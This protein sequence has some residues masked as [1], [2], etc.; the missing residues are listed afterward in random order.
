M[1]RSEV[2][3]IWCGF[4]AF[5]CFAIAALMVQDEGLFAGIAR[6]QA[7]LVPLAVF[8]AVL[9]SLLVVTIRSLRGQDSPRVRWQSGLFRLYAVWAVIAVPITLLILLN[10]YHWGPV[11]LILTYGALAAPPWIIHAIIRWVV[12]PV[13]GWVKRGFLPPSSS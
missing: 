12:F 9:A 6:T 1:K 7:V 2:V 10:Q 11:D 13:C 3:T 8:I 4:A 5:V